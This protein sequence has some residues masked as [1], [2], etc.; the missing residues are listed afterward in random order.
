MQVHELKIFFYLFY[1]LSV[2]GNIWFLEIL[3]T[4]YLSLIPSKIWFSYFSGLFGVHFDFLYVYD[5]VIRI[6]LVFFLK[7]RPLE[8]IW[9]WLHCF[10]FHLS[11]NSFSYVIFFSSCCNHCSLSPESYITLSSRVSW[12]SK[13]HNCLATVWH[14]SSFLMCWLNDICSCSIN[15]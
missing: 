10:L 14:T 13:V 2:L 12:W 3:D 8:S 11:L 1:L 9:Y 15:K 4:T 5:Q 6:G 7:Y